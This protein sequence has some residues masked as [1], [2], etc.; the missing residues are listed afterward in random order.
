MSSGN[1][2]SQGTNDAAQQGTS[3]LKGI[4]GIGEQIRGEPRRRLKFP[5]KTTGKNPNSRSRSNVGTFNQGVDDIAAAG[6]GDHTD[7][8]QN[9]NDG[10]HAAT[11]R[12]GENVRLSYT[13]RLV[14]LCREDRGVRV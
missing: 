5:P 8:N 6:F 12:R 9:M 1:T 13:I 2:I 3:M 10:K 11:L 14:L 7:K 4:H